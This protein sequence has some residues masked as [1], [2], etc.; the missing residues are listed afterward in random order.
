MPA[1]V[2]ELI[3][4]LVLIFLN[5]VLALSEMAVVSSRKS[6]LEQWAKDG[7]E[8]AKAAIALCNN[9]NSFLATIQVGMTCTAILT[10]I[11]GGATIEK[12]LS[13]VFEQIPSLKPYSAAMGFGIVFVCISYLTLILGE[14]T[15]KRVGI[16]NAEKLACLIS[17]PMWWLSNVAAPIINLLNASTEFIVNVLRIKPTN[18]PPVT[19]DEI[20]LMIE[21]GT[22]AGVFQEAEEDMVKAVLALGKRRV[23]QLMTPRP[24]LL[25]LDINST[26]TQEIINVLAG[27]PPSRLLVVDSDLDHL[28]GYVFTKHVLAQPVF[29]NGVDLNACLKQPLFVPETK[30]ALQVLDMFKHSGTHIAIILDEYGDVQGVVTMTDMLKAI[31]GELDTREGPMYQNLSEDCC[32]L[33]DGFLP[34]EK[35]KEILSI[36]QLPGEAQKQYHTLAGFILNQLDHMPSVLEEVEFAEFNFVVTAMKGRRIDRVGVSRIKKPEAPVESKENESKKSEKIP[37]QKS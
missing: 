21:H 29:S 31:V 1:T 30:T 4:I 9:P 27:A 32:W 6:R 7:N 5:G 37:A 34:L 33:L 11:Y 20:N 25:Y 19:S 3:I 12:A 23:T 17:R 16:A 26:N 28:L 22:E 24:K 35:L 18:E 36:K 14:L 10:G 13:S 2:T 15:P 8:G